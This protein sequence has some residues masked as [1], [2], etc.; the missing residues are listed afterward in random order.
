[1]AYS[2]RPKESDTRCPDGFACYGWRKICNGGYINW[3]GRRYSD[4][5]LLPWVGMFVW[6]EISDWLAID[7]DVFHARG[8]RHVLT[9]A[10]METDTEYRARKGLPDPVL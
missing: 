7:L 5:D 8:D 6:I 3:Y 10:K 9:I 4:P 2:V 1:M